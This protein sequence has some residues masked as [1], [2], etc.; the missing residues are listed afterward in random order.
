M[1]WSTGWPGMAQAGLEEAVLDVR[2]RSFTS[3]FLFSIE[4]QVT[5]GFG[6]RMI[7]EQ[8]PTAIMVL[9]LQNIAGLIINAI[10]LGCIFMKTAQSHRRAETLIFSRHAVIAVR[11]NRLC[12]MTR[13]GDLRKS[14]IIG[15]AVRLQVVRKTTTPE[16]EV[17]PIHQIDVRTESATAGNS[18]FLLA[19]LI[20]CHV[21]D[22][23]SPLYDLSAAELQCSDLE[24][25]VILEGVVE[26]TGIT[27]QAR[28]SYVAEEI[29]WGHRFVPIVTEEEGVYSVD[30]SKFG[31]T[32]RVATP[33]CSARELDE[34]P[35]ILIQTLQK[36]ELAPELAAQEEL[37]APRQLHAQGQ[38]HAP[39]QLGA[40]GAQGA[41]PR[42]GGGPERHHHHMTGGLGPPG[43]ALLP[44][45]LRGSPPPD[46][47]PPPLLLL[48]PSS[49]LRPPP[50]P[51]QPLSASTHKV[52]E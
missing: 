27:T 40:R 37:H 20:I 30:Y 17:I 36:S 34:K 42:A 51:P 4:V 29:Q 35:S 10:M 8:C 39:R 25:I 47:P 49:P 22:R 46:P 32:A 19:P 6:G 43:T 5:V 14:M 23:D 12:F 38:L 24:V 33:R 52:L 21:I 41:V 15:A 48:L 1:K 16:G 11:D 9:I 50:P 18:I 45:D 2:H 3:A 31:N 44:G 28:T 13:V 7:T 26:T